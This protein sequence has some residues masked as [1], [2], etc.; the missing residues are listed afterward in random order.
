MNNNQKN[1]KNGK[2]LTP[3]TPE[4]PATKTPT[5]KPAARDPRGFEYYALD[6]TVDTF[7]GGMKHLEREKPG[8]CRKI[9]GAAATGIGLTTTGIGIYLL[10]S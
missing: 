4:T 6:K 2:Q 3:A 5:G 1:N 7:K 9:A 8:T 10:V